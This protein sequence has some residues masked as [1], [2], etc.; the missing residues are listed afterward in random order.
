MQKALGNAEGPN[1]AVFSG[2]LYGVNVKRSG[3]AAI[4]PVSGAVGPTGPA[5]GS[6]S[7]GWAISR[8]GAAVYKSGING[9]TIGFT[10]IQLPDLKVLG[11]GTLDDSPSARQR[12]HN[13]GML[14]QPEVNVGPAG[15][16]AFGNRIF[17]R[18]N[19][20]LWCIGDPKAAWVP[21]ET[22]GVAP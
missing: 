22:A 12:E 9:R 11:T 10:L 15:V 3:F 14:G 4:D 2:R 5:F 6:W 21:P 18:S 20:H 1:L 13:I 17:Y 19:Q 16:T 7:V 8:D